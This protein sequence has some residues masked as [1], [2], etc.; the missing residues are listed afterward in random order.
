M[1]TSFKFTNYLKSVRSNNTTVLFEKLIFQIPGERLEKVLFQIPGERLSGRN[2]NVL[3]L[4]V[5]HCFV[6]PFTRSRLFC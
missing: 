6:E 5:M 4:C 3:A 2:S 1:K